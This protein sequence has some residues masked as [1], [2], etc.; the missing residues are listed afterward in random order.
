MVLLTVLLLSR[1]TLQCKWAVFPERAVTFLGVVLSKNGGSK[2]WR[3]QLWSEMRLS[4]C[5]YVSS[6]QNNWCCQTLFWNTQRTVVCCN[7]SISCDWKLYPPRWSL[8]ALWG[9]NTYLLFFVIVAGI[10]IPNFGHIRL[11]LRLREVYWLQLRLRL[12]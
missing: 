11:W 5:D 1:F 4:G 12:H 10:R 7:N 9:K 8:F 6:C 2:T 3:I